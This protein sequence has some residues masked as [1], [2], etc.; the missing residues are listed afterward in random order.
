MKKWQVL[1]LYNS[2]TIGDGLF[3]RRVLILPKF[4]SIAADSDDV[5]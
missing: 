5:I 1:N 3:E 4:L 2:Q